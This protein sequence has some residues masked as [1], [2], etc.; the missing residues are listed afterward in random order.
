MKIKFLLILIFIIFGASVVSAQTTE[1]TYQGRLTDSSMAA[2]ASYD[3]EFRLYD[4][5]SGGNLLGT[6]TKLG[7]S[8]NNGVFT[9]LLTSARNLPVRLA[10]WKLESNQPEAQIHSHRLRRV[11]RLRPRR[12]RLKV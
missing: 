10:I 12:M 6:Q 8:V 7:V 11:S 2:N 4:A 1:F 3:F 5:A 9:V